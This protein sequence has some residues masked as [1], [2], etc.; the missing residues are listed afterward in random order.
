LLAIINVQ[1]IDGHRLLRIHDPDEYLLPSERGSAVR[2]LAALARRS[3]FVLRAPLLRG[4]FLLG[5]QAV[6]SLADATELVTA[7]AAVE[8]AGIEVLAVPTLQDTR[9]LT[10]ARQGSNQPSA[11]HLF[12]V[13]AAGE[14]RLRAF[15]EEARA[16][17]REV[18]RM[19][20]LEGLRLQDFVSDVV[21]RAVASVA[22]PEE[23]Q[24]TPEELPG[25]PTT[26]VTEPVTLSKEGNRGGHDH[27]VRTGRDC[28]NRHHGKPFNAMG[29]DKKRKGAERV[30]G[31]PEGASLRTLVACS[32]A[33]CNLCW[34]T[35]VVPDDSTWPD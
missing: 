1:P 16:R 31:L 11:G 21:Q 19:E 22:R 28:R 17:G 33:G 9:A 10:R 7:T 26:R 12:A 2:T 30:A 32:T 23:P 3:R 5:P 15:A 27:L 25:R 35:Y 4:Q 13:T 8:G 14:H 18:W 20:P 34:A 6:A 29:A 24:P